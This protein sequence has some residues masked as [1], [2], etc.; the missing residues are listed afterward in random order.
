MHSWEGRMCNA[1]KLPVLVEKQLTE[2]RDPFLNHMHVLALARSTT[3]DHP[4]LLK[5]RYD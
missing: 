4:Y 1:G 5:L 3:D 2:V